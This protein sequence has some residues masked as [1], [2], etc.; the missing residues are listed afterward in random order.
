MDDH[1]HVDVGGSGALEPSDFATIGEYVAAVQA[2]PNAPAHADEPA[3]AAEHAALLNLVMRSEA[4][5]IAVKDGSWFDPDTWYSNRVPDSGSK[6]LIPEAISV[7]YDGVSDASI[8]TIRVDGKLAFATDRDTRLEVDTLVVD[9]TGRLEIGTHDHPVQDGINAEIVIANNGPIDVTWDP[10]ILSRGVISHGSIEIHGQ[11]KTTFLKLAVDP[12]RGDTSLQLGESAATAGWKVGD[13]IV[14]TGTHIIPDKWDGAKLVDQGTQDEVLTI[15]SIDGATVHI[16]RPLTYNHDTPREDLKAYVA[17]YTRNVKIGTEDAQNIPTSERGH[18]MFMHSPKVD[19]EYAEFHELGRTDKSERALDA[20]SVTDIASD[21]NVKGRY[22]LH[23][24]M[25][26][27][28]P[29]GQSAT[30]LGNAVWGS[31]GWGIVQHG[32]SATLQNNATFNTFGAG[33]V[34]ETGNETGLWLDNIAIQAPGVEWGHIDKDA[35]DVAAFDLARTGDGFWFQGRLVAA[36]GNVAAGVNE[37][38]V[39]MHRGGNTTV[40]ADSLAQPGILHGLQTTSVN[41][42]PIQHF[43]DNEVL[44]S[45]LGLI[46]VKANPTQNHDVRSVFDGFTAWEVDT[47]AL[48]EYTAHYTLIDFDLVGTDYGT[49]YN[50]GF[51]G[52]ELG[53]NTFDVVINGARISNFTDGVVLS[54]SLTGA[55]FIPIDDLNYVIIDLVTSKISNEEIKNF[56]PTLDTLLSRDS[57][58]SAGTTI[59]L[60]F[61]TIP[62]WSFDWPAGRV[63]ILDGTK[64]DSIG[65]IGYANGSETFKIGQTEMSGLLSHQGYY[66]TEDGRKIVIIEEYFSDRATGEVFKVGIP[67]Q[68]ADNVPLTKGQWFLQDGDAVAL[69]RINLSSAAPLALADNATTAGASVVINVLANDSDPDGNIVHLDGHTQAEHGFVRSNPDGSVIYTPFRE[70]HGTDHFFYWVTDGNGKFTRQT[71]TVAVENALDNGTDHI[72]N[73]APVIS[74]NGGGTTAAVNVAENSTAVTT[75]T[76]TDPDVSASW[77][78]SIAGGADQ[79]KF[80]I[81]ASTGALSFITAPNFEAPTDAGTDNVYDVAVQV[82]DGLGGFDTQSIAVT[83]INRNEAPVISSN[84]AGATAAVSVAENSTAVTTVTAT[85]PDAGAS[86]TYSIAGGADQAKFAINASTGALS[87]ITAPNFEAPTDAGSDNIY[88]VAVQVSDGLGGFDTQGIA[89]TVTNRNEAPVISSNGGGA[90]AVVNVA[91]NSTGVTTVTATDP[92]AGASRTY[93][94]AG[95]ADQAKF[96]INAST[97]ALSFITAPNFE[98]P[99]DAG[100]DNIYDVAVQVSDGLGGFDTQAIAVNVRNLAPQS[101]SDLNTAANSVLEG[102][103]RGTPVGITASAPDPAGGTV[104]YSLTDSAG[105]KFAIDART[106]LVT[107]ANGKLLDFQSFQSH[108]IVVSASDRSGATSTSTFFIKVIDKPV[109]IKGSS[110]YDVLGSP[111]VLKAIVASDGKDEIRGTG[112]DDLIRGRRGGDELKGGIGNDTLNGGP[113]KDIIRG[114]DGDDI[115]KGGVGR[116][117]FFG[118]DGADIFTYQAVKKNMPSKPDVIADFDRA[119]GDKIDLSCID[120]KF[121]VKGRQPFDFIGSDAFSGKSGELRFKNGFLEG[122]AD[123][124]GPADFKIKMVDVHEL[125]TDS[126]ILA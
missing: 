118:G 64:T 72:G 84:G 110:K 58:K 37:G 6:V 41:E 59:A 51:K 100:S 2:L 102:S 89:V 60:D 116:D 38:F 74:S 71:V 122:D 57:L 4:T 85:D 107:V 73:H 121:G 90:T 63:V 96:A 105:G 46:V 62:I 55:P 5:C 114:G 93:S 82:S 120:A 29:D 91:E 61:K 94:I 3:M 54:K 106:G 11:E 13:V 50:K 69:G 21:T 8:F 87:F 65:A 28:D 10:M 101:P 33:F 49:R 12:M 26:G 70:F 126:L 23:L 98:G 20:A 125:D 52:I 45:S 35:N 111:P 53:S 36:E 56:D 40:D 75:V 119:G 67:I 115:I 76:A 77:T 99:T 22:A 31:P 68:L 17:D 25:T 104:A 81:N 117:K 80:A 108:A 15:T 32:S 34:A 44:A 103:K 78:Y 16:D 66:V 92:D 7:K 39:Y 30:V 9:K 43:V 48:L 27:V 109:P 24:H 79:A 19:V 86:R 83:V 1:E 14:L 97:G 47:G 112:G 124:D 42:P 88:D 123:G 95:G 113:G 18:V